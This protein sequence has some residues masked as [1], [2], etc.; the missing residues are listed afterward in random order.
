MHSSVNKN[1]DIK[2]GRNFKKIVS[3]ESFFVV[4]SHRDAGGIVK[5]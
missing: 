1:I 4:C 5:G 3:K 2:T